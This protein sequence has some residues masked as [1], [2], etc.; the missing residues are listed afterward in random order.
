MAQCE[1]YP[2]QCQG[3]VIYDDIEEKWYCE[4]HFYTLEHLKDTGRK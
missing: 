4:K 2:D 3:K 1:K